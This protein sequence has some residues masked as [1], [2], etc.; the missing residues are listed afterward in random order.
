MKYPRNCFEAALA[1]ANED[2][3][4]TTIVH[5]IP[6]GRGGANGGQRYWHAW[7]EVGDVVVDRSHGLEVVMPRD[8][9]YRIGNIERTWR[10]TFV[11]AKINLAAYDH[12]GPWVPDY[13][14]L[15]DAL[16]RDQ[17]GCDA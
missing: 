4:R 14:S 10:F 1:V 17:E 13:E 5:G 12:Y 8:E 16:G 6:L 3:L 2:R 11:E 15:V 7:A 9:Y